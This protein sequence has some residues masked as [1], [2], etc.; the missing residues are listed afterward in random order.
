MNLKDSTWPA[1]QRCRSSASVAGRLYGRRLH[2][3]VFALLVL[4]I[5]PQTAL[6]QSSGEASP[7]LPLHHWSYASLAH[8]QGAGLLHEGFDPGATTLSRFEAFEQLEHAAA[9]AGERAPGWVA[10]AEAYRDR[11]TEEFPATAERASGASSGFVSEGAAVAG[12]EARKNGLLAKHLMDD[13]SGFRTLAIRDVAQPAGA[14]EFGVLLPPR[15]GAS[16]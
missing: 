13:G 5:L 7:F 1:R 14:L 9:T 3:A 15:T 2:F 4:V 10:L 6:T 8:L 11:F 16:Q 12:I